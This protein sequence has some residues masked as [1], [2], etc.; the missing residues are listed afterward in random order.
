MLAVRLAAGL[1]LVGAALASESALEQHRTLLR[2]D[3][4]KLLS[5][6]DTAESMMKKQLVGHPKIMKEEMKLLNGAEAAIKK[7]QSAHHDMELIQHKRQTMDEGAAVGAGKILGELSTAEGMIKKELSGHPKLVQKEMQL[8]HQAEDATRHA[9]PGLLQ[10]KD[11]DVAATKATDD[12][13]LSKLGTVENMMQK[14]LKDHPQDL[15]KEEQLLHQAESAA[16][17]LERVP[18]VDSLVEV[19]KGKTESVEEM[20]AST[21]DMEQQRSQEMANELQHE[22]SFAKGMRSLSKDGEK[23]QSEFGNAEE[24]VAQAFAG[25]DSKAVKTAMK[26]GELLEQARDQQ[27]QVTEI[28]AAEAAKA[29][30]KASKIEAS[31]TEMSAKSKTKQE[32]QAYTAGMTTLAKEEKA[33]LSEFSDAKG[34]IARAFAG[35]DAHA[36]EVAMKAGELLDEARE[37]QKQVAENDA[38]EAADAPRLFRELDQRVVPQAPK[39][40]F[41]QSKQRSATDEEASLLSKLKSSEAAQTAR[42]K[43]MASREHSILSMTEHAEDAITRNLAKDGSHAAMETEHEVISMMEQAKHAE[44]AAYSAANKAAHATGAKQ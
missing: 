4:Q 29:E 17:E 27:K 19:K 42:F 41:L 32:E 22:R 14:A 2:L 3:G 39:K 1:F 30:K 44:E 21:E 16:K 26:V 23:I 13:A 38:K 31:F 28:N 34:A 20:R 12:V 18:R 10:Q 25:K 15:K 35:K 8:L 7:G 11:T 43:K 6:L 33:T 37:D 40:S 36:V 9:H 24:M 5:E